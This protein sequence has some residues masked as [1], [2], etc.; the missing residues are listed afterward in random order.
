MCRFQPWTLGDL[1]DFEAWV[2]SERLRVFNAAASA[3][4]MEPESRGVACARIVEARPNLPIE[5]CKTAARVWMLWRSAC[6]DGGQACKWPLEKFRPL[7]PQS[8]AGLIALWEQVDEISFGAPEKSARPL[9]G[10]P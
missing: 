2:I 4:R 7:L 8:P 6:K 1:I 5:L 10:S 9:D 3:S